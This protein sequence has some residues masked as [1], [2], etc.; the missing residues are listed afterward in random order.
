MLFTQQHLRFLVKT[1]QR[2]LAGYT[3]VDYPNRD[4][5]HH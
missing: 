4:Y 3:I 5:R 2:I 1:Q